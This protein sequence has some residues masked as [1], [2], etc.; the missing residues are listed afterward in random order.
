MATSADRLNERTA[1]FE[2]GRVFKTEHIA[3]G[4]SVISLIVTIAALFIASLSLDDAKDAKMRAEYQDMKIE[5]LDDEFGL[6]NLRYG[7]LL[8]YLE[9]QGIEI[10]E[11]YK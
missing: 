2:L 11:E 3:I 6:V 5:S 1:G 10:P 4:I 7:Q 9:S 8:I